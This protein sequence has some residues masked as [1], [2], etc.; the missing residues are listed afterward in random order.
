MPRKY[1]SF[2]EVKEEITYRY[3]SSIFVYST[4]ILNGWSF[5]FKSYS[6]D[7]TL[8]NVV[9]MLQHLQIY[10]KLLIQRTNV[11]GQVKSRFDVSKCSSY[12][13]TFLKFFKMTSALSE[14]HTRKGYSHGSF[15]Y[16]YISFNHRNLSMEL[17][18]PKYSIYFI[19]Y[20]RHM[21]SL[22]S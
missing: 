10:M 4:I 22:Y 3:V 21:K 16:M 18:Y 7:F 12:L 15:I 20:L 2:M 19:M 8:Q 1:L 13:N 14:A 5:F 11:N 17:L 6:K 9:G